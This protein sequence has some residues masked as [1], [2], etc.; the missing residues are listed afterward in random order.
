MQTKTPK[1]KSKTFD[2]LE[3]K[4]YGQKGT[5]KRELYDAQ[6]RLSLIGELIKQA[7]EDNHMTQAQLGKKLGMGKAYVSR[8]ENNVKTQRLDTIIKVLKALKA[9]LFIRIKA[10]DGMKEV[11]LV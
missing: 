5:A 11:K 4:Y 6:I 10:E 8:M 7:R 2:E 9:H 3:T 1:K